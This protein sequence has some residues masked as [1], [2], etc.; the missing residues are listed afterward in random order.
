MI[1]RMIS[2]GMSGETKFSGDL[3]DSRGAVGAA[4]PISGCRLIYQRKGCAIVRSRTR[5]SVAQADRE[6]LGSSVFDVI[7]VS[8]VRKVRASRL[9]QA[10]NRCTCRCYIILYP[11]L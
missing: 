7:A 4:M 6:L 1:L 9:L 3:G 11:Y 2:G 8:K 5:G 10:R